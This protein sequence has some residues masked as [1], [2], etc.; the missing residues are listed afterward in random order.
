MNYTANDPSYL[1]ALSVESII[2][3][4]QD[5]YDNFYYNNDAAV[6]QSEPIRVVYDGSFVTSTLDSTSP[7]P[8]VSKPVLISTV[9]NEAGP[10]IY[11]GIPNVLPEEQLQTIVNGT[12]G[13]PRTQQLMS[14]RRYTVPAGSNLKTSDARTQLEQMGTD[15]IW[16]C[17]SWTFARNY[18]QNGGEAYVGMYVVGATYPSN[19]Q[20]PYCTQNGAVCHQDDIEIVVRSF[21]LPPLVLC[22]NPHF[23]LLQF[24]TVPNPTAIQSRLTTEM[25]ARYKSF[26]AYGNPNPSGYPAWAPATATDVHALSLGGSGEVAADNCDPNFWGK[27]VQYDYQ[28]YNL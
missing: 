28:F 15:Y 6:G 16:K 1:N 26:L 3:A 18:V 27:A 14:S 21:L 22:T 9:Q 8:K 23:L 25:Q 19:D 7:F 11:R 20:V 10:A 5:L 13:S 24:G 17:A 2:S 4:Q 12:F